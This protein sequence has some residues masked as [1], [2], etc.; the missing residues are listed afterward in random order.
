M[1]NK[2]I[3]PTSGLV[4]E[5]RDLWI[6]ATGRRWG[7]IV[8]RSDGKSERGGECVDIPD[9]KTR[10]SSDFVKADCE[11]IWVSIAEGEG[12]T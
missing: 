3:H 8:R 4:V 5:F 11:I 1:E 9:D 7:I 12:I 10:S 6:R 2:L